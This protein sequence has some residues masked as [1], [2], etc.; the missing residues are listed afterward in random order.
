MEAAETLHSEPRVLIVDDEMEHAEIVAALLR[1]R[2]Y[3]V[4]VALSG[5]D[6]LEL[7]RALKPDLILL[8]LY[9]PTVDGFSTAEHLHENDE[10]RSV[11]IIFLS[12]CDEPASVT[13]AIEVGCLDYLPKPFH[14]A[15]L[16]ACVE[17]SLRNPGVALH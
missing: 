4:A 13:R 16:I 17:R 14:A 7:A 12:A 15:E 10:T 9:M 11:P 6:A 8:D 1:R 3:Q 2:G 5:R